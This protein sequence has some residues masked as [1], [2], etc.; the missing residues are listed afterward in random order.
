MHPELL[1]LMEARV[2]SG[3]LFFFVRQTLFFLE[4]TKTLPSESLRIG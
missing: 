1:L 3:I 2:I 4:G